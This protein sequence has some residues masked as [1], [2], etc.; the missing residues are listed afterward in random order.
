MQIIPPIKC[1]LFQFD[2]SDYH[3]VL[4][5]PIGASPEQIRQQYLKITRLIFPDLRHLKTQEEEELADQLL[6]KFVNPSYETL[7]KNQVSRQDHLLVLEEIGKRV[8][9]QETLKL[10]SKK[11]QEILQSEDKSQFEINYPRRIKSLAQ[12]QYQDL[13]QTLKIIAFISELNLVYLRLKYQQ[14]DTQTTATAAEE[15]EQPSAEETVASRTAPYIRRGQTFID[16]KSYS[17]AVIEL[18]DALTIDPQ[19]S[20]AH[21]LLGLAYVKQSQ[22]GMAKVHINKAL[23][24][25]PKNEMALEGKKVIAKLIEVKKTEDASEQKSTGKGGLF[26]GL[27]GKKK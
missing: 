4:G 22:L 23:E 11:A 3:A 13:N 27:F 12:Q 10:K 19:N 8:A 16:K 1:G 18:R 2:M 21:T 6:A 24:L 9:K 17:K 5:V 25:D 14:K 7:F 20:Q 26:G 15:V